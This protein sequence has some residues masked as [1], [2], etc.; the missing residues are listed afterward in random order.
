MIKSGWRKGNTFEGQKFESKIY[1]LEWRHCTLTNMF[2][3]KGQR[4]RSWGNSKVL[5]V[6]H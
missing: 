4:V 1:N 6:T 3:Q 5:A 2:Y